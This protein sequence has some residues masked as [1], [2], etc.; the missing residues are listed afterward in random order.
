MIDVGVR[1]FFG[2][3]R[4]ALLKGMPREELERLRHQKWVPDPDVVVGSRSGWSLPCIQHFTPYG[5]P[6]RR[7]PILFYDD[8]STMLRRYGLAGD[9]F[10]AQIAAGRIG[11]PVAWVD[12]QPGWEKE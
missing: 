2:L 1:Q 6:F 9:V 7:A 12:G 5:R 11:N 8:E 4:F 3:S 10:W